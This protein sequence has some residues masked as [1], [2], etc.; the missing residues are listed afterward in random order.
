M[1]RFD[2][3]VI[4]ARRRSHEAR[5]LRWAGSTARALALLLALVTLPATGIAAAEPGPRQVYA[6]PSPLAGVVAT[7]A[8]AS[9]AVRLEFAGLVVD[10]LVLAYEVELDPAL[11]ERPRGAAGQRKLLRWQQATTPLLAELHAL[12]AALYLATDVEVH[13]DRHNRILLRID[14]RPLWVAWPRVDTQTRIERELA[15]EFCRRHDCGREEAGTAV[16]AGPVPRAL[17]GTWVF[18]QRRPPAW[19]SADG[20][21]CEFADLSNRAGKEAACRAIVADLRVLA[22]ALEAAARRG[23]PIQWERL[24]L[25]HDPVGALHRVVVNERGDYV[26]VSVPALAQ[27]AV[28]WGAARRW[29][30]ARAEGRAAAATILPAT[31]RR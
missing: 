12:Q 1:R 24:A 16:A 15:A 25:Q 21:R 22:E 27:T 31:A 7:L 8:D 9:P 6:Q 3:V 14:G 5:A 23:E 18:S 17:Q 20:L 29:L 11:F 30:R 2:V 10:A 4:E 19:E 26:Q 13:L 28:D